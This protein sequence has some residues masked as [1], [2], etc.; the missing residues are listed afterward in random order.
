MQTKIKEFTYCDAHHNNVLIRV[1]AKTHQ[2]NSV[3]VC[4]PTL[5]T[6]EAKRNSRTFKDAASLIR[7]YYNIHA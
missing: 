2:I 4:T 6:Y 3:H 1:N 7:Q 5:E